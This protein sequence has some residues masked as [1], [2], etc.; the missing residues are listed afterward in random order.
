MTKNKEKE[1]PPLLQSSKHDPYAWIVL[2]LPRKYWTKGQMILEALKNTFRWSVM[3]GKIQFD[4]PKKSNKG[5]EKSNIVQIV[6]HALDPS[7]PEPDGYEIVFPY[8]LKGSTLPR[9]VSKN[10]TQKTKQRKHGTASTK[11]LSKGVDLVTQP[12]VKD[13]FL[14][15]V[16]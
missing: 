4:D 10:S 16:L 2:R 15:Q 9:N 3:T 12:F 1:K 6:H 5:L 11:A 13:K 14:W 7:T 8:L